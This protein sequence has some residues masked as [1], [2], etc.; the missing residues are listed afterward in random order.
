MTPPTAKK[1]INN[2]PIQRTLE[3]ERAKSAWEVVQAAKKGDEY[4]KNYGQLARGA[5][6]AIMTNGL[7]QTLAFWLAKNSNQDAHFGA[8][9]AHLSGWVTGQIGLRNTDLL[10]WIIAD[11]DTEGYRMATS[12]ALA[13]LV[14]VKRFSEAELG[15]EQPDA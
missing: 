12:E 8:L 6:A 4:A 14:W 3:Q 7:G 15:G 2:P 10:Q 5:A 9:K 1:E 13:F 11:A